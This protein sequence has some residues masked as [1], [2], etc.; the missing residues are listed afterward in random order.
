AVITRTA[1]GAE[2]SSQD[3]SC[4]APRQLSTPEAFRSTLYAVTD[5]DSV[6][7]PARVREGYLEIIEMGDLPIANLAGKDYSVADAA[8][9]V[10]GVPKDCAAVRTWAKSEYA[11]KSTGGLYGFN[12]LINV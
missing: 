1:T 2:I 7:S 5:K 9:H 10:N 4:V 12:T 11:L 3:T 8:T 6:D